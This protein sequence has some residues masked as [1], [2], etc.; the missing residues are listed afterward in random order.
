M[1]DFTTPRLNK[2]GREF[3]RRIQKDRRPRRWRTGA[4]QEVGWARLMSFHASARRTRTE[5]AAYRERREE[6]AFG[7][8]RQCG[9]CRQAVHEIFLTT[10]QCPDCDGRA[11]PPGVYYGAA[12]YAGMGAVG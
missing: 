11:D 2:Q 10:N 3:R 4:G 7:P 1:T 9:G 6:E 12:D 8:L 5:N